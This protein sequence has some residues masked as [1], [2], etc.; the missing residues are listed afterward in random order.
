MVL[1]QS[2][3]KMCL[4]LYPIIIIY[5][6]RV[7]KGKKLRKVRNNTVQLL[8]LE[9]NH[10]PVVVE[11]LTLIASLHNG[12][13]DRHTPCAFAFHLCHHWQLHNPLI[14]KRWVLLMMDSLSPRSSQNIVVEY[15]HSV[16]RQRRKALERNSF[17]GFECHGRPWQCQDKQRRNALMS[18]PAAESGS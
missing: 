16:G 12:Y 15:Q 3:R 10:M 17:M 4:Y 11:K 18:E 2:Q 13:G 7:L 1:P 5:Y 6:F 9:F 14:I 8:K